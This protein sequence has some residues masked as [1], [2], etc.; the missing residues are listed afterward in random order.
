MAMAKIA[1][2]YHATGPDG[3]FD[4]SDNEREWLVTSL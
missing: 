2:A 4:D 1:L 3:D